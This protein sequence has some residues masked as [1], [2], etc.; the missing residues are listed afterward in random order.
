M[1][2]LLVLFV[3]GRENANEMTEPQVAV[4]ICAAVGVLISVYSLM[5]IVRPRCKDAGIPSW[6]ALFMLLPYLN[7]V[8]GIILLCLKTKSE[9]G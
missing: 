4:V 2:V 1:M 5:Y 9:K 3:E 7:L 6:F 8:F